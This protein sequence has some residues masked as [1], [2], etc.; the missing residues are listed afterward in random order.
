MATI[1]G[2]PSNDHRLY[3]EAEAEQFPL[4]NLYFGKA[5][6]FARVWT[7]EKQ[8]E[9]LE[10]F[11]RGASVDEIAACLGVSKVTIYNWINSPDK[12]QFAQIMRIGVQLAKAWW[13]RQ[14]RIGLRANQFNARL[15]EANM[16][17]RYS[18]WGQGD[19]QHEGIMG[20]EGKEKGEVE[21][22]RETV[23]V[24]HIIALADRENA[25]DVDWEEAG[26]LAGEG[27]KSSPAPSEEVKSP[28][29]ARQSDISAPKTPKPRK[30][31]A[32]RPSKPKPPKPPGLQ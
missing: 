6:T 28:T 32:P 30:P 29:H 16:R 15:W 19:V 23:N 2:M 8:E 27:E 5:G 20:T 31:R 1:R 17:N 3:T 18:W 10:L 25:E 26:P 21:S 11:S 4:L 13:D 14:G 12:Q 24:A 9:V 7:A 22:V